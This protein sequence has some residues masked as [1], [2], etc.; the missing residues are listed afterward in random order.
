MRT[1][2]EEDKL[3]TCILH[4]MLM[5]SIPLLCQLICC[6]CVPSEKHFRR[7]DANGVNDEAGRCVQ[8]VMLEFFF[9]EPFILH[10]VRIVL[11]ITFERSPGWEKITNWFCIFSSPNSVRRNVTTAS[12]YV[13]AV[14]R[15]KQTSLACG[16]ASSACVFKIFI[17]F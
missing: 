2:A 10:R 15:R 6:R 7:K 12:Q 11:N 3:L 17:F 5:A 13:V 8:H 1:S 4:D 14:E 16:K 9:N